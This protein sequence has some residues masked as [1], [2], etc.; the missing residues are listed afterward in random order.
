[1]L[2]QPQV[3]N[4][5]VEHLAAAQR[6]LQLG[7]LGE[8]EQEF[9]SLLGSPSATAGHKGLGDILWRKGLLQQAAE[10]Y[11]AALKLR[12]DWAEVENNL[13]SV[14]KAEGNRAAAEQHYRR[15]IS[16]APSLA[17]AH[18]NL[19]VMLAE[20]G[21]LTE[22]VAHFR[23]AL[24]SSPANMAVRS[25]LGTALLQLGRIEEAIIEFQSVLEASPNDAEALIGLARA[26]RLSGRPEKGF[27]LAR[28][29]LQSQP[30]FAD[31]YL[32]AGE[33]A[34]ALGLHNDA[35]AFCRQAVEASPKSA[36]AHEALGS[37]L[38]LYGVPQEAEFHLRR[39]LEL[40]P[41]SASVLAKLG[42]LL[43]QQG[44]GKEAEERYRAAL[45]IDPD[46]VPTLNQLA[47]LAL[48]QR[49]PAE[50]LPYFERVRRLHPDRAVA[51]SNLAFALHDLGRHQEAIEACHEA[52]KLNP[53]LAEAYQNLGAAQQTLG[54]LIDARASY[55][56]AV[57]LRPDLVESIFSLSN[58]DAGAAG[59]GMLANIA[60]LLKSEKLAESAKAQ[61]YFALVR[62]HESKG[63]HD[64]A[65]NAAVEG[66]AL[67]A[68]RQTYDPAIYEQ[69]A[70][71]LRT[72]FTAKF[73]KDRESYGIASERPIFIVGF[74]RSGTTLTEQILA[75]HPDVFGAGELPIVPSLAADLRRW[76]R[77]A[78]Q[79]PQG[80]ADLK[81]PEVLRLAGAHRRY[82]RNLAGTGR[83]VT[84]KMTSNIFYLGMIALM[85]P[86]AKIVYC[87]RD[88]LDLFVS[89]YF[90]LFRNPIPYRTSQQS[91]AHFY[92]LQESL[93]EH[94]RSVLPMPILEL[95]YERLIDDQEGQSR[96]LL[97]HCDLEWDPRC[98]DFH[99]VNRPILTGSDIQ[100]RKPLYKSSVGRAKP[101]LDR[102]RELR[103]LLGEAL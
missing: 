35:L 61:L 60:A 69:M 75:S 6:A 36:V 58:L 39:S 18:S 22:A 94:W 34:L 5:D 28:K 54:Q 32:E 92:K 47:N 67:E 71:A 49:K 17:A 8:A 83:R 91:F 82:T 2:E 51:H 78:R 95:Q 101:Y 50:A 86:Q 7:N 12:P 26:M 100:V 14:H 43:A 45:G 84:D 103:A 98:L 48:K 99:L 10:E 13:G 102:L 76:G 62:L 81:E 79:F 53:D 56:R 25:N 38:A 74:P 46:H 80:L 96:A 21:N 42:Q 87:R 97:S 65:F 3:Q 1:M 19:G 24:A 20:N 23:N 15:A 9:R 72:T 40:L 29:A 27:E 16:I 44:R 4:H 68:R 89:S 73:F 85:Y 64:A 88:P 63:E 55:E 93:L 57:E 52:L 59:E 31:A 77:T 33:A 66:N 70:A 30:G 37:A 11:R 90:M 41:N